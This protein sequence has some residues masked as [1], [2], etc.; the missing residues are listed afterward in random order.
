MGN[1]EVKLKT[2]EFGENILR[3]IKNWTEIL[4]KERSRRRKV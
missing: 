4:N 2:R 3:S 1:C